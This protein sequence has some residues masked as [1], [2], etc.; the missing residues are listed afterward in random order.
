[1]SSPQPRHTIL[2]RAPSPPPARWGPLGGARRPRFFRRT[3]PRRGRPGRRQ[4]SAPER[5]T[6]RPWSGLVHGHRVDDLDTGCAYAK[7]AG[8]WTGPDSWRR[9][10]Q[11]QMAWP[12]PS[13]SIR[14]MGRSRRRVRFTTSEANHTATTLADGHVLIAGGRPRHGLRLRRVVPAVARTDR[15]SA[16]GRPRPNSVARS[17]RRS[18]RKRAEGAPT[19]RTAARRARR[20]DQRGPP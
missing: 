9:G 12:R 20:T 1:M 19:R 17:R 6:L 18:Q 10:R 11:R 4:Q 5:G 3:G 14:P 15:S 7:S 13:C 2:P 16:G 8:Q